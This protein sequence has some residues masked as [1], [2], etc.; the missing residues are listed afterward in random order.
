MT[1]QI[2]VVAPLYMDVKSKLDQL[3]LFELCNSQT[4]ESLPT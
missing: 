3:L 4:W 1:K 2:G